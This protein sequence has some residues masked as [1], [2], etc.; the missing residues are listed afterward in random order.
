MANQGLTIDARCGNQRRKWADPVMRQMQSGGAQRNAWSACVREAMAPI[1]S[2]KIMH[3]APLI[4]A[5]K[6]LCRERIASP[7]CPVATV[8]FGPIPIPSARKVAVRQIGL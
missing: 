6:P 8:L 3:G 4:A 7:R 5:A 1:L 2:T